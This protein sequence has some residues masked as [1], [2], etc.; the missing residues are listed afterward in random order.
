MS[1]PTNLTIN[2]GQTLTANIFATNALEPGSTFTFGLVPPATNVWLTTSGVLTLTNSAALIG[3]NVIYVQATDKQSP[4]LS[5]TNAFSV[6]VLPPASPI[7]AVSNL[8]SSRPSFKFSFQ[9]FTNITWRIETA[10]N[11]NSPHWLPVFTNTAGP[12]GTLLFTDALA[13]NYLQRFYRAVY[14]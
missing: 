11:L 12:G 5:A 7:L 6:I 10:T 2:A 8:F 13:T 1:L 9:T 3:T 4:P 14:P